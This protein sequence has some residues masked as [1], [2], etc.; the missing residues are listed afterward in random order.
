MIHSR[1]KS[2][3]FRTCL[4]TRSVQRNGGLEVWRLDEARYRGSSTRTVQNIIHFTWTRT[5]SRIMPI[6][7]SHR[8]K[9]RA[10]FW[11]RRE[12]QAS[13]LLGLR[14]DIRFTQVLRACACACSLRTS[15]A[16]QNR[17]SK[18]DGERVPKGRMFCPAVAHAASLPSP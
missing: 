9:R 15:S 12:L 4:P 5:T 17:Q 13:G 2:M 8:R 18:R 14:S 16:T 6:P 1:C 7:C 3:R 10:G 11:T